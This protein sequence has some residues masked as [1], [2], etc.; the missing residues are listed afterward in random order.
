MILKAAKTLS[1]FEKKVL[2]AALIV[3]A[4]AGALK[5]AFYV[6]DHTK[7]VQAYGGEYREG[8]T[9]QPVFINPVIPTT[10]TDRDMSRLIFGNLSDIAQ[11]IKRSDD[12]K[13]WNVRIRDDVKWHDGET[14]TSD[15]VIFSAQT[16]QNKDAASYLYSSFQ[17]ISAERISEL[18]IKF[19]LQAPYAFFEDEHLK[20]L[21]IIPKHIFGD[22]PVQNFRLSIYGLRPVGFG[23][24]KVGGF[25]KDDKGIIQSFRLAANKN[26]FLGEPKITAL[27][28]KFFRNEDELIDA[29]NTG[30]IDGFG[31]SSY[32]KLAGDKPAEIKIRHTL[33]AFKSSRYYAIFINQSLAGKELKNMKVREA[34]SRTLDRAGIVNNI[35]DS[36]ASP[37][38]GPTIYTKEA[39]GAY[40]P[41]LIA[42]LTLNITVPEESFL[43]KTANEVKIAWEKLGAT[44]N[45]AVFPLK[46]VQDTV[47]KNTDYE[48]LMFGNITGEAND[49]F[50][51]WHSSRR[52][53]PDQNLSLYQNSKTDKLLENFRKDFNGATRKERL[54][55]LSDAIAADYPAVFLYSPDYIYV[56]TPNLRGFDTAQLMNTSSDRFGSIG[57]WYLRT[58][59]VWR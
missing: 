6:L 34:L 46:T 44:V 19:V 17:G 16:I 52:F 41:A 24:Y 7:I 33:N 43:V 3:F 28:F 48:L 26:Y 42:G 13:T 10:E 59:R 2:L 32:E 9:G 11:G 53:Y 30:K 27:T 54:A 23:P 39:A 31:L 18:E 1:L 51:F 56:S 29:Y 40:D 58:K 25:T 47:L 15:D 4:C 8:I 45:V 21:Y 55:T 5:S 50:S 22:L 38:Y 35:F 12:G 14:V 20:S 49:L 37:L 36:Y 57:N